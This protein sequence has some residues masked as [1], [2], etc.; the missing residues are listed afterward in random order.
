MAMAKN[1]SA[2]S[3]FASLE[4]QKQNEIIEKTHTINSKR[5]MQHYVDSMFNQIS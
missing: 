1:L 5:E 3:Y 4:A 2:M